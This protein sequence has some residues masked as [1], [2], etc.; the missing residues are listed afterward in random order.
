MKL[1]YFPGASSLSPHIALAESGL[2]YTLERIDVASHVTEAGR[3]YYLVNP[4]GYVPALEL[5][6]G[7]ILTEGS[8]IVQYIAD[9][10]PEKQLAPPNGTLARY[11][12]QEWLNFLA[13]EI[14][15]CLT[16]FFSPAV[17]D[18]SKALLLARLA[19][20]LGRLEQ[21]L[22]SH[23]YLLRQFTVAD[24]YLFAL[25]GWCDFLSI[26]LSGYPALLAFQARIAAR[27][28]VH[29]ALGEEGLLK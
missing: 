23:D 26:D 21:V 1:Y 24:G 11:R 7:E 28:A 29:R 5:P 9:R 8:A 10:V 18:Q 15:Q 14:H 3:D 17:P 19:P 4:L 2:D 25:L 16:P 6:D 13:T 12:L 27:P 22:G 20:R